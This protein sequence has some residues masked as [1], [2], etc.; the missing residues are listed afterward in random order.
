MAMSYFG[1]LPK[2]DE[3][4]IILPVGCRACR[5]IC[6]G[7]FALSFVCFVGE[8]TPTIGPIMWQYVRRYE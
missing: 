8:S 4:A 3:C 5:D 7:V 2:V 6:G 1:W